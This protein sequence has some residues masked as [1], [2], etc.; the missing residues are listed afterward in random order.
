MEIILTISF[1]ILPIISP[2]QDIKM[3]ACENIPHEVIG[4]YNGEDIYI[5]K[6]ITGILKQTTIYHEIG[7]SI[8]KQDYPREI[9]ANDEDVADWFVWWMLE[10]KNKGYY[11]QNNGYDFPLNVDEY[12]K[13][14]CSQ[15]CIDSIDGVII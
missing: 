3:Y 5:D 10:N 9:F 4:C 15:G 14:K 6:N 1:F 8:M 2:I 12:F 7:H 13:I 11:N